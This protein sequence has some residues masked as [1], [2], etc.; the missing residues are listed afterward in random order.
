MPS[1][2]LESTSTARRELLKQVPGGRAANRR[3]SR[4]YRNVHGSGRV[5]FRRA[6]PLATIYFSRALFFKTIVALRVKPLR[7]ARFIGDP[8]KR[9]RKS[10]SLSAASSAGS[11]HSFSGRAASAGSPVSVANRW[12][13]G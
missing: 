1:A 8:L 6:V 2:T 9:L 12:F 3:A 4:L 7:F 13:H 11:G 5:N 10:S